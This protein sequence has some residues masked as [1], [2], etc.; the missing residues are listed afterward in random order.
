MA[1]LSGSPNLAQYRTRL[2]G[3][4]QTIVN[5]TAYKAPNIG[6]GF[7]PFWVISRPRVTVAN[8]NWQIKV[9]SIELDF[10]LAREKAEHIQIEELADII[11]ADTVLV[12]NH[13]LDNQKLV[14]STLT[15]DQPGFIPGTFTLTANSDAAFPT[16]NGT[17]LGSSYTLGF[18]HRVVYS[19]DMQS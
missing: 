18:R 12:L 14:T 1:V 6:S 10:F 5:C 11:D 3:V 17:W 19:L 7:S 15:T 8:E 13:F 16:G 2:A 4:L 9:W